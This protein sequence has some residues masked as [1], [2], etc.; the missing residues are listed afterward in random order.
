MDSYT[1][2]TD[3]SDL[4]P[5]YSYFVNSRFLNQ[6]VPSAA[7]HSSP[8]TQTS[9]PLHRVH[10]VCIR[11][12]VDREVASA[13]DIDECTFTCQQFGAFPWSAVSLAYLRESVEGSGSHPPSPSTGMVETSIWPKRPAKGVGSNKWFKQYRTEVAA[14]CS[15][16][17]GQVASVSIWN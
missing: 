10:K 4:I 3:S 14:S 1:I 12:A 5:A 17:V 6:F 11:A 7:N 16:L 2:T 9:A 8:P 15:T 13:K